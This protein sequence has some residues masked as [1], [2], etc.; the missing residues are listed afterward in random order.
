MCIKTFTFCLQIW[1]YEYFPR[2]RPAQSASYMAGQPRCRKWRSSA[3]QAVECNSVARLIEYRRLLDSFT[4]NDVRYCAV[5]PI[6]AN[7][8]FSFNVN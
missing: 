6:Y 5:L 1:I 4:A 2:L 3:R 7:K 8:L